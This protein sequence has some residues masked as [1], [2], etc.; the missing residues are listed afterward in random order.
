MGRGVECRGDLPFRRAMVGSFWLELGKWWALSVS[1][2]AVTCTCD[3]GF[4]GVGVAAV[5]QRSG[6]RGTERAIR[7]TIDMTFSV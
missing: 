7:D 5:E 6:T 4:S 2:G 1:H 3:D